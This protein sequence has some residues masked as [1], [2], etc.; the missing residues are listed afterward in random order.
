MHYSSTMLDRRPVQLASV[1]QRL[2]TQ[3]VGIGA[4]PVVVGSGGAGSRP[5]STSCQ[6]GCDRL[7]GESRGTRWPL[8][9]ANNRLQKTA[10]VSD[11]PTLAMS[12]DSCVR[13]L[14]M[15]IEHKDNT[16]LD[17]IAA[18]IGRLVIPLELT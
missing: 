18:L 16:K 1:I 3:P 7:K 5:I 8:C 10:L 15:L 4:N 9:D 12:D 14:A 6:P 2:M 13:K 17:E 11:A